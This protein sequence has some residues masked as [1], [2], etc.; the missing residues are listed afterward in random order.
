MT[1]A[2]ILAAGRGSRLQQDVPKCLVEVGGRSLL[3]HQLDAVEQAGVDGVTL[4]LGHEHERV[5]RAAEGRVEVVLNE[6]FAETNSL[7]SFW[8]ARR[9]VDGDILVLNSDVLFVPELLRD[10]L[11]VEGS[12]LAID[13]SSGDEDEH[14]KVRT[15]H[16]GLLRMSKDLPPMYSHGENLGLVHLSPVAARAAFTA[17]GSLVERGREDDWVGAAFSEVA[18]RHWISCVDVAGQP[19][20]EIDFPADLDFAREH[21]WPEIAALMWDQRAD[22]DGFWTASVEA[23]DAR[24]VAT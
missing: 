22:D 10:L 1:Q 18:R 17:A 9:A 8:L 16:G 21:T 23:D 15:R 2:L 7:Y 13:S 11:E 20:V 24:E 6:R 19:W 3:H 14:M 4:V 5:E 12:A